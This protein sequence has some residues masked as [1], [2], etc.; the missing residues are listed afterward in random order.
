MA[1]VKDI[2]NCPDEKAKQDSLVKNIIMK[3]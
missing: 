3:K 1:T 2:L